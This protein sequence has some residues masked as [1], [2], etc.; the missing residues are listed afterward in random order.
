[1]PVRKHERNGKLVKPHTRA[2]ED[3]TK[4]KRIPP[5]PPIGNIIGDL[6]VF[7][8]TLFGDVAGMDRLF[9]SDPKKYAPILALDFGDGVD[10]KNNYWHSLQVTTQAPDRMK[11]KLAALLH[12]IGK[13]DTF[14]MVDDEATFRMHE[15]VGKKIA[16]E[17]LRSLGYDKKTAREVAHLV[18]HSGR[19]KDYDDVTSTDSMVRRIVREVGEENLEDYLD[20]TKADVTSKYQRN[21]DRVH[22]QVEAFRARWEKVAAADAHAAYRPA[23]DGNRVMEITGMK[24]GPQVGKLMKALTEWNRQNPDAT[25]EEAEARAMELF[26]EQN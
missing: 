10:H 21:H 4:T 7:E 23:I 3:K 13:P 22:A 15:A 26:A 1:M 24:G 12:D 16:R 11:V 25:S 2:I 14:E 19:I 8:N 20:L 9:K 6:K 17:F 5:P 18:Y